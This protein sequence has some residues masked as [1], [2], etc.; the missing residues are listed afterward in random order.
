MR[1]R[2][3]A[4][5]FFYL[6]MVHRE[7]C[8]LLERLLCQKMNVGSHDFVVTVVDETMPNEKQNPKHISA[9]TLLVLTSFNPISSQP[10]L[11]SCSWTLG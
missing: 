2:T 4:W 1:N 7:E 10:L 8:I 5:F 11:P 6:E 3:R 9:S